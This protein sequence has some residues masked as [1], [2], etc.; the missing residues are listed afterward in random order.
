MA[1][2]SVAVS[3]TASSRPSG[4]GGPTVTVTRGGCWRAAKLG[5]LDERGQT[6]SVPHR[7]I[8]MTGA[9]VSAASRAA[10]V[11]PTQDR[12]E[13]GLAPGDG[14]LG[15]D[16]DHLAGPQG[17]R[18]PP[19]RVRRPAPPVH[20]DA[21]EGPGQV[22]H[23]RGVEHLLLGQEAHRSAQAGGHDADGGHVEVA[24]VVGGQQHRARTAG[25]APA[26][27]CRTG[28]RGRPRAGRTG[29]TRW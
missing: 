4:T 9:P 7:P 6:R 19:H 25:C 5:T 1:A 22:A 8:G 17:G 26:R 29:R 2:M 24:A 3:A 21:A 15:Q 20:L 16:D 12:I 18:G 23:D 27:G 11:W 28:R 13:E 14:P 10:P